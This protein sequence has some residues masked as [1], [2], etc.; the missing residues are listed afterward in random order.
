VFTRRNAHLPPLR[1]FPLGGA[2]PPAFLTGR[3]EERC[4]STCSAR[5]PPR[6]GYTSH[7][8]LR[9][10]ER[11]MKHYFLVAKDVGDLTAHPLRQARRPAGQ[12]APVLSRNDGPASRPA[13]QA[14]PV[15]RHRRLHRR[16]RPHQRRRSQGLQHDPVNLIRIFGSPRQTHDLAFHPDA[17]RW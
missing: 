11:F 2:L 12:A 7:P 14:R 16:Q 6:L 3:A 1:G 8:G 9:A 17:M 13:A 4:P 5:S 10:V 15:R